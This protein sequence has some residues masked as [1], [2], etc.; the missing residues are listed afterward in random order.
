MAKDIPAD[1]VEGGA[2]AGD[3]VDGAPHE[4]IQ[5]AAASVPQA[6]I[7]L[8]QL[9]GFN[10]PPAQPPGPYVPPV[11]PGAVSA[12]AGSTT[13]YVIGI[14]GTVHLPPGTVIDMAEVV[15]NDLHLR[16]PDGS[17]IVIDLP[18]AQHV[19]PTEDVSS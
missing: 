2:S 12:T 9:G 10:A 13:A 4:P 11:P 18:A 7:I 19:F 1:Q 17:L 15:G 3:Q 5:L 16:Q 8:A 6:P 14:D